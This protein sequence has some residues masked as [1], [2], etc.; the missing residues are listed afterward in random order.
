MYRFLFK[1]YSY[2]Y[3]LKYRLNSVKEDLLKETNKQIVL[4]H[5]SKF[6][7]KE[8]CVNGVKEEGIELEY[9]K[10]KYIN[11]VQKDFQ[12]LLYADLSLEEIRNIYYNVELEKK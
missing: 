8:V 10:E 11:S 12:K 9:R 7:L 3:N 1:F 5:G 4:F 6:G 2:V